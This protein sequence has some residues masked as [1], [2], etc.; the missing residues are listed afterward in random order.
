MKIKIIK[1]T[2]IY[3]VSICIALGTSSPIPEGLI[4]G[5]DP[6]EKVLCKYAM[7]KTKSGTEI[8]ISGFKDNGET[9]LFKRG[10]IEKYL[11]GPDR[12]DSTIYE[13]D[14]N[15]CIVIEEDA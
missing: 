14:K 15:A 8:P 12:E 1:D 4:G 9:I 6:N 10:I 5:F 2:T 7:I 11:L 13:V 3:N